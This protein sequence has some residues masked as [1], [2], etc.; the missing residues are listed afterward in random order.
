MVSFSHVMNPM[1]FRVW[2][3]RQCA[4]RLAGGSAHEDSPIRSEDCN[5]VFRT[6]RSRV[7]RIGTFVISAKNRVW[8]PPP[9]YRE[10]SLGT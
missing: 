1:Q 9:P 6:A 5:P 3:R 8:Y 7:A 10:Q 2:S 4:W